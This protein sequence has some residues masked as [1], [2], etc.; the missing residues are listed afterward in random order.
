MPKELI[1]LN[2]VEDLGIVGQTVK[3]SDGYARNY[4]LPKRLATP[5]PRRPR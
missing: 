1:L 4:L 5:I 2:D 3:V